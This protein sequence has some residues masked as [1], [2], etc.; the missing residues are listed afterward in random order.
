MTS[1]SLAKQTNKQKQMAIKHTQKKMN[2]TVIREHGNTKYASSAGVR[3]TYTFNEIS[4][5]F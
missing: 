4:F 1:T 3:P 2:S 5:N